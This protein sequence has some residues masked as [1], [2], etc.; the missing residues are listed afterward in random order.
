M[1]RPLVLLSTLTATLACPTRQIKTASKY[2][3]IVIGGGTSGLVIANRLSEDRN[4]SVLVIEAGKSVLNNANVTDV[5][6]YGLAFG[7]DIDWQYK[8]V[9][10]TYG[11]NKELVF[12]A[13]KAVAGT[14]AINGMAYTRAE[15]VQIDAWQTIGNEGWTW[16]KLLPYYL[17][18]EKLTIPSQSQV[19]KGASY[20]ASLHGKSGP[21]DVGFF[22]I[23]DND[24][25][26]VLN[27]T[28]NGLGIPWVEDVNGGKMRGFNIFPSTINVAA[29]V[30]EDAARAYYWPVASRQN[31]HLLVDT[32]VN[33]IIWQDKANNSDHVTAS[34]V[35]VTLAN[36]TTSVVSANREV[37]VSAGALKSPGILELSGIGDATLLE[38]HEIPVQVNLPTVG[39]NL[40]D[41]TNAQ[42]GAAIKANMTSATHVVY[43]NVYDIYGNQTD[44]LA[45]SMQK[46]I[47]DYAR[48]TAEVSN[49]IMKAS[50]LEAL[51]QV[52]Y[53]LIFK[54]RTPIAEIL[55]SARGDNAISSEYWTLLPFARGNVHISSSDPT[56]MPII[57]PNFFMLDWD[58]DS[59]IAV[60]KYIRTSFSAGPLGKLVEGVTIPD[61]AVVGDDASDAAWKKWLLDGHYR[62][63]FHPVG[64]A[65]MMPREKGGVVDNKLKVYGTSNVRVVDASIL[66]YQVC[67]HLT[68]TLY[69][70]AELTAELIKHDSA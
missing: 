11:G 45:L 52:Q 55:Y 1:F 63:N 62:S 27:T 42:S 59:M 47:K 70:M 54:Q 34:G 12:R 7:T 41:Q 4:V 65:A 60:A 13:G 6:G 15:D 14:S 61:P 37:I 53:D 40:Q 26:G 46:K 16:E 50:D 9:N 66:P 28:M 25:T 3:Y 31:L 67:G 57:N 38:K 36:G 30:R 8:S 64:T 22:D 51:F 68:S 23:P 44:S 21:L 10:Q 35:E 58:L 29:N 17:Q 69:A 18:S 49:G 5:D 19:S 56:A 32:F 20:N 33:R 2:D 48:A 43:P 39:E 24:L